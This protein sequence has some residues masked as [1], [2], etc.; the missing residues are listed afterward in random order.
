VIAADGSTAY[1]NQEF[2]MSKVAFLGLGAMGSRMAT[3][4]LRAG[5]ELTVWNLT[6]QPMKALIAS[7]AK[8]AT[9]PREAAEGNDFIMT[10]VTNDDASRQVWLDAGGG[11]LQGMRPG[12]IAIDSS[13]L[14]PA[15]V[16]E[17][18]A[19][20]NKVGVML[21][22]AMV[23]GSTP[24][25]EKGELVFLVGG[26]ANSLQRAE[27]ILKILGSSVCHAGPAGCGAMAKL[28]TNA[29]MGVQLAALAELI[30]MLK[31]RHVDAHQ[32]LD[33][34]SATAMWNPHLT[35]DSRSMLRGNFETQFPVR[36]LEKDLDYTVQT[37][38]GLASMPTVSAVRDLFRK[39]IDENLG[40]LNM[41]AVAKLFDKKE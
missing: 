32:I 33:A 9:S 1:Q 7:G 16:C 34:V 13:T 12:A 21:L 6:P 14:T 5:H 41:T 2:T 28:V 35:R 11:A 25:A 19:A 15:W 37:G 4:L 38:G 17:L 31:R 29:L 18:A 40:N 30:G 22:D 26:D 3:N 24:Q 36:L 23:S 39:A 10:M 27:P 8:A 20:M